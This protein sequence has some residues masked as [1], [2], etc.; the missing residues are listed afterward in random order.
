MYQVKGVP[1]YKLQVSHAKITHF[2]LHFLSLK[3]FIFTARKTNYEEHLNGR[4]QSGQKPPSKNGQK[5]WGKQ[6]SETV[7]GTCKWGGGGGSKM[8]VLSGRK[9]DPTVHCAATNF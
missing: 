3:L 7:S 1:P 8:K 9:K 4:G 2:K 5:M 6:K